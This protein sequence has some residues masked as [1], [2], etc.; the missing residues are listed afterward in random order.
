MSLLDRLLLKDYR[1]VCTLEVNET[2]VDVS[3]FPAVDVHTHLGR[4]DS[5]GFAKPDRP[6][7][8]QDVEALTRVM[9]EIGLRTLVN[10]DGAWGRELEDSLDRYDRA[11]P[12]RI[13]TFCRLDYSEFQ[14]RGFG[15]RLADE[16]A[17]SISRGAKGLKIAKT[18]GLE[19]RRPDG[20][21]LLPDDPELDEVWNRAGELD[22]P[23]LI[24]VADPVAFFS[25]PDERNEAL[26]TL[27][28]RPE[29]QFHSDD[30]PP[31]QRLL[32]SLCSILERHPATDFIGAHVAC[33]SENLGAVANMCDT[34]P[35]LYPEISARINQLG[36]QPHSARDFIMKYE[37]RVLYGTD[38]VPSAE[39]HRLYFRILESRDD[40][41][42]AHSGP[43]SW[44]LYGLDLPAETLEK[45]YLKNALK[46]LRLD[47]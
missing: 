8:V 42:S 31:F 47:V 16:L 23:V 4:R 29:W 26:G 20:Q 45:L 1:P 33:Y 5:I 7:A 21:Y 40:H 41:I 27:E 44:P 6:W 46:V 12:G 18:L 15:R 10:L 37:D 2:R 43:G 30:F 22:V 25:P 32:D 28:R 34:Y 11:H 13:L 9:D 24:H 19:A 36:R 17:E 14:N 3:R 35:N 39:N 38:G